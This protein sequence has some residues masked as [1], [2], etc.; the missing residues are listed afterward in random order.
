MSNY[1]P[2]VKLARKVLRLTEEMRRKEADPRRGKASALLRWTGFG[3]IDDLE[4]SASNLLEGRRFRVA[5]VGETIAVLGGEP[6]T[7]ARH[8]AHLPGVAW[9]GL[10]YTSKGGLESLL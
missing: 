10:G 9:I 5:R 1:E 3:G 6:A 7:A 4:R 2:R 8:C